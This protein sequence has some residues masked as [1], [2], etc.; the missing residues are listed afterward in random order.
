MQSAPNEAAENDMQKDGKLRITLR[1][2]EV[3][4]SVVEEGSLATAARRLNTSSSAVSQQLSNLETALGAKLFERSARP[5]TLTPAGHVFQKRALA[6]LDEATRA[7]SELSELE[8]TN[9][10]QIRLSFIDDFDASITPELSYRLAETLPGCNVVC[11]AAQSHESFAAL[12]ARREDIIVATDMQRPADWIEQHPLLRE[13]FVLVTS[14]N[15]LKE[16][17]DPLEQLLARPMVRYVTSQIISQQIESHLR[18][19]RLA[20]R[21]Q[22]EYDSN[23]SVMAMVVRSRGWAI[24]TPLAYFSV[25][26]FHDKLDLRPLPFKGFS[27]SLSLYA[28][29]GVLGS[30][31]RRVAENL[32]GLIAEYAV[33]QIE[34]EAPWLAGTIR[35]MDD[36][37]QI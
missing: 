24:M 7:Q 28:R 8:L 27:R 26:R 36:A 14:R 17:E 16:G 12:E 33:A 18:R 25:Q 10:P 15:L 32:R 37:S 2:A 11:H 6:M 31:P 5:L 19:L 30:L 1:G 13:P 9:L 20:P 3:F 21:R 22:F 29:R 23:A 34:N 35:L 4:I